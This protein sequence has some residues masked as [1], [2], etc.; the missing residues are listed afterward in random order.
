M[1]TNYQKGRRKEYKVVHEL[2]KKGYDIVQRS[3][4][5]RSPIDVWAVRKSDR[6]IKLVQ[7]K[8]DKM[9]P[10]AKQ[11]IREEWD[12]LNGELGTFKVEFVIR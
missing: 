5:S 12:W 11:K 3:A 7:V 2:R 6:S 9:S 1:S 8:P 4:G 10:E